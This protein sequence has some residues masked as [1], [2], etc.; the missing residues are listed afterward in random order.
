MCCEISNFDYIL[1]IEQAMLGILNNE[2][3]FAHGYIPNLAFST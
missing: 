3:I 2:T 1:R